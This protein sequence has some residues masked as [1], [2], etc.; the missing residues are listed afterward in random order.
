M[1]SYLWEFISCGI[2]DNWFREQY[3]LAIEKE[4]NI[5][6]C[7]SGCIN[8][9]VCPNLKVKNKQQRCLNITKKNKM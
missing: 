3:K 6:P 2:D 9:G 7:E 5:K 8:C 1:K 4:Q